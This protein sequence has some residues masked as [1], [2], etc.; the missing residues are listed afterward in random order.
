MLEE[1]RPQNV[2]GHLREDP[3]LLLVFLAARIVVLLAGTLAA[4]DAGIAGITW[5]E[6]EKN[7]GGEKLDHGG[8]F[9][10]AKRIHCS[11]RTAVGEGKELV[12]SLIFFWFLP[13]LFLLPPFAYFWDRR[14]ENV[15]KIGS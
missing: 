1:P 4:A 3:P 6:E 7:K 14:V 13:T 12:V 5:K 9:L 11:H 2:G 15:C 8:R 10:K